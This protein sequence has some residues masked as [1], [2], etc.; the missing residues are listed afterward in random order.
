MKYYLKDVPKSIRDK[1]TPYIVR[2][3]GYFSFLTKR[4]P[5]KY[6]IIHKNELNASYDS[7]LDAIIID[8]KLL[9]SLTP[10]EIRF[11]IGHEMGHREIFL[12]GNHKE[13]FKDERTLES[14]WINKVKHKFKT[15]LM[16]SESIVVAL[17]TSFLI[18]L[19]LRYI[20]KPSKS[21]LIACIELAIFIIILIPIWIKMFYKSVLKDEKNTFKHSYPSSLA[22][23]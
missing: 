13:H 16:A 5:P 1:W 8:D 21:L 14:Q 18:F 2:D 11:C 4:N 7:K 12:N 6:T 15:I 19:I 23:V 20:S 9:T 3:I 22:K 17:P 10:K